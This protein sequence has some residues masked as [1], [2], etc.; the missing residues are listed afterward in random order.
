MITCKKSYRDIPFAHRQHLHDGRCAWVHG[1]NWTFSLTFACERT[2]A[3]GFV[4]DFGKL[5][6]IKEWVSEHLDHACLFNEDDPAK[7]RLLAEHGMLFRA[8]VL[9]DCSCEGLAQHLHGIFDP[10]VRGATD[11]R[12]WIIAVEVWEDSKNS[13]TYSLSSE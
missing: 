11:G 13:A 3:N 1:H 8:Y 2:D 9:P 12:A 4:V 10:K 7:E 5:G 6:Y